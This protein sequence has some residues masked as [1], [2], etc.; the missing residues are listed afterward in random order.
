MSEFLALKQLEI[1]EVIPLVLIELKN[2]EYL[3][4]D[5]IINCQNNYPRTNSLNILV[6]KKKFLM[7]NLS[8]PAAQ[9]I[10]H[11]QSKQNHSNVLFHLKVKPS[12]S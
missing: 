7:I 5:D 11:L 4:E 9:E 1:S 2:K 8:A 10:I 3:R 6:S 12:G